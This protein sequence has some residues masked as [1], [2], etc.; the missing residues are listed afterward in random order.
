M[1][2]D[3]LLLD[4][5]VLPPHAV[6]TKVRSVKNVMMQ[7]TRNEGFFIKS[8]SF[9]GLLPLDYFNRKTTIAASTLTTSANSLS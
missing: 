3:E 2:D 6:R 8:F 1:G 5:V 4:D 7:E 9:C